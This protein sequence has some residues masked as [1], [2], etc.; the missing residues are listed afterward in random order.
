MPLFLTMSSSEGFGFFG[1]EKKIVEGDVPPQG[2][3]AL[4]AHHGCALSMLMG[5]VIFV[6]FLF[7][8][9]RPKLY[10]PRLGSSH[11]IFYHKP[12]SSFLSI[13]SSYFGQ[14]HV[15]LSILF[16]IDE[17]YHDNLNESLTL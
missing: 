9:S 4:I 17:R 7:E 10:R 13:V 15:P 3:T 5:F 16:E 11:L 2:I 14:F 1:K 8:P 6:Q 12:L